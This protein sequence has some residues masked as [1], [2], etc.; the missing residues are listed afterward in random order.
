MRMMLPN[1]SSSE[2]R[3]KTMN[4]QLD[5]TIAAAP[6]PLLPEE[7]AEVDLERVVWDPEYRR[8]VIERLK[9]QG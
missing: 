4:L 3:D 8:V 2:V 5:T 7:P 9:E 6:L 1:D